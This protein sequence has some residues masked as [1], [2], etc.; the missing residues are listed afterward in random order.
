M[1]SLLVFVNH[2]WFHETSSPKH[3]EMDAEQLKNKKVVLLLKNLLVIIDY[4]LNPNCDKVAKRSLLTIGTVHLSK[5]WISRHRC[6]LVLDFYDNAMI[7]AWFSA[8][9]FDSFQYIETNPPSASRSISWYCFWIN[10]YN[11]IKWKYEKE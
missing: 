10:H 2:Q 8:P 1:S 4:Y 6:W 9:W 3:L 11:C 5:Y 7:L